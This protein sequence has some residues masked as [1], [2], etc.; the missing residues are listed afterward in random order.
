LRRSHL[1]L[2]AIACGTFL[3]LSACGKKGSTF[4]PD[5]TM[6]LT[7]EH[8]EGSWA[9]AGVILAGTVH[10]PPGHEKAPD[11]SVG[12]LVHHTWYPIEAPP[13]DGCPIDYARSFEIKEGV[14]AGERF[15]AE[16]PLKKKR[17]ILYIEVRLVSREGTVGPPSNHIRLNVE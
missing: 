16:L 14:L 5:R 4:L 15:S 3:V 6:A 12:C 13:C 17:G 11:D 7:V 1:W 9:E 8:L 10:S 2:L